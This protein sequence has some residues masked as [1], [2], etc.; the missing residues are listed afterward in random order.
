MAIGSEQTITTP[1]IREQLDHQHLLHL[2][3]FLM[4]DA[5]L[6]TVVVPVGGILLVVVVARGRTAAVTA[7]ATAAME[8][9]TPEARGVC[10]ENSQGVFLRLLTIEVWNM[11]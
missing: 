1:D 3:F 4:P 5:A 9:G 8:L 6:L 7:A 2:L 10:K 11:A